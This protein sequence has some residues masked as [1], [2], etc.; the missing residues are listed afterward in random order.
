MVVI[1]R[2]AEGALRQHATCTYARKHIK[3]TLLAA[4][5]NPTSSELVTLVLF[6]KL[7]EGPK[8]RLQTLRLRPDQRGWLPVKIFFPT[9]ANRQLPT[10]LIIS[11]HLDLPATDYAFVLIDNVVRI[12][13]LGSGVQVRVIAPMGS[14][15]STPLNSLAISVDGSRIAVGS[16]AIIPEERSAGFWLYE[17]HF[18]RGEARQRLL[19]TRMGSACV[20]NTLLEQ[21]VREERYFLGYDKAGAL[22]EHANIRDF[23]HRTALAIVETALEAAEPTGQA[24]SSAIEAERIASRQSLAAATNSSGSVPTPAPAPATATDSGAAAATEIDAGG[25]GSSTGERGEMR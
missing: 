8:A 17:L 6:R 10:K 4:C 13:S 23:M 18:P 25:E 15:V 7:P 5:L 19:D 12:F 2:D 11:G 22:S 9:K 1:E 3:G 16:S 21:R 24:A 14:D 20:G